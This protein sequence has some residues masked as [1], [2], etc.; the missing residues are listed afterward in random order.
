MTG[1]DPSGIC[2]CQKNTKDSLKS[3]LFI[4]SLIAKESKWASLAHSSIIKN[5]RMPVFAHTDTWGFIAMRVA[6]I[7]ERCNLLN[8]SAN[9]VLWFLHSCLILTCPSRFSLQAL[10]IPH[11]NHTLA[12][13]RALANEPSLKDA[14]CLRAPFEVGTKRILASHC[15]CLSSTRFSLSSFTNSNATIC[16]QLTFMALHFIPALSRTRL[17]CCGLKCTTLSWRGKKINKPGKGHYTWE[18]KW[19]GRGSTGVR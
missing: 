4:W 3:S 15:W 13:P 18:A 10:V 6:Q 2:I 7:I 14:G 19:S 1:S 5:N 8:I 12:L 11:Q 16:F 17:R 9:G